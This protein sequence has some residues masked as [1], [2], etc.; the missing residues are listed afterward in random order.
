M[1]IQSTWHHGNRPDIDKFVGARLRL[2]RKLL[3]FSQAHMGKVVGVTFQQIQKYEKGTSRIA[4]ARLWSLAQALN[5]PVS[6]FFDGLDTSIPPR[7]ILISDTEQ[8]LCLA[9]R[10]LSGAQQQ[11]LFALVLTFSGDAAPKPEK[12]KT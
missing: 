6:F 7:E 12:H 4:A 5:V 2:R 9:L 8:R 1:E 11:C 3:S 10:N